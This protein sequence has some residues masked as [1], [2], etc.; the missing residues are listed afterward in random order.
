VGMERGTESAGLCKMPKFVP[1]CSLYTLS[2][3]NIPPKT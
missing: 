1:H 3:D 2:L